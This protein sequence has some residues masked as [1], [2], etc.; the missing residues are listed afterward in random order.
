MVGLAVFLVGVVL[1]GIGYW[2]NLDAAKP[3][4]VVRDP[5]GHALQASSHLQNLLQ[6]LT[7]FGPLVMF[8]ALMIVGGV[9]ILVWEAKR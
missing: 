7:D 4:A 5:A 9:G 6:T 2:R 3:P 1:V 8:G